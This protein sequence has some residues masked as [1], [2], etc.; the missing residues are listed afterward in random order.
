MKAR[1]G[2][3]RIIRLCET[4]RKETAHAICQLG[5]DTVRVCVAC[6]QRAELYEETRE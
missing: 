5:K 4:C 3:P 2:A 6:L 1:G